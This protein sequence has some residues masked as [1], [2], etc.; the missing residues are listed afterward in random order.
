MRPIPRQCHHLA[1]VILL[2]CALGSSAVAPDAKETER[3]IEQLG[4]D[5]PSNRRD[6]SKKLEEL[7]EAVLP[8]LRR[9]IQSHADPDVRL[10]AGLVVRAIEA[11]LWGEIR[12]FGAG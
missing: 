2:A 7:G 6:A 10:R 5:N 12:H 3:L 9:A 1:A 11:E 8:L 4:S